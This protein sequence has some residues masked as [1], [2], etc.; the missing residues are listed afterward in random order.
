MSITLRNNTSFIAQY[1]VKKGE[2]VIA[3]LPGI[4]PNAQM[5]IPTTDTFQVVASTILDGNTYSSAPLSV[6]GSMGFLAQVLQVRAQGTYEFDVLESP[7]NS[8]NQLSFQKTC[9]NPVTFT[10]TKDG[11]PLQN[12]VVNDSF[13]SETLDISDTFYIY[14]VINGVTTEV[15][16]TSN[17]NATVTAL[18]NTSNLEAGYFSLSIK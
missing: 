5:V 6:T 9:I 3:R 18:D 16:T 8:S 17:A 10:I 2:Q 7:S 15:A 12:V 14:A 4:E 13:M 11:K 1:V